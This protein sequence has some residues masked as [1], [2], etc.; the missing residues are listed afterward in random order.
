MSS[1]TPSPVPV[2]KAPVGE[3][4]EMFISSVPDVMVNEPETF[5]V[6][7]LKSAPTFPANKPWPEP[8]LDAVFVS[9]LWEPEIMIVPLEPEDT[10]T[11]PEPLKLL[12]LKLTP[13]LST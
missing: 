13:C 11:N 4:E 3:E 6:L 10:E 5:K 8:M 2:L 1:Q 7:N 9:P 12:N